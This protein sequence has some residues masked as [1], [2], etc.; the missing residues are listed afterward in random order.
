MFVETTLLGYDLDEA[1]KSGK[2]SLIK[3]INTQ[4]V[5]PHGQSI[6]VSVGVHQTAPL[7]ARSHKH[8]L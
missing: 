2:V 1:E 6:V 4:F 3:L 8:K 5:R 7:R